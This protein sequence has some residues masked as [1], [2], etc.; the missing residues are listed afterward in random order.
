MFL[1]IEIEELL[2]ISVSIYPN[3]TNT[4]SDLSMTVSKH[5][6]NKKH[7]FLSPDNRKILLQ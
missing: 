5:Y 4:Y 1:Y 2:Q 6:D 7:N 3:Q